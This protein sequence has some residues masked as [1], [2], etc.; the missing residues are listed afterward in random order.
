MRRHV[1]NISVRITFAKNIRFT[2]YGDAGDFP[3]P[4]ELIPLEAGNRY[5]SM[6]LQASELWRKKEPAYYLHTHALVSKIL[7]SLMADREQQYMQ[8]SKYALIASA[9]DHI[10]A[11]FREPIS[12][13]ALAERCGISDEYLRTLFRSYTGQTPLTYINTL[14]LEHARE[15]LLGGYVSVAEA[16]RQSGFESPEYFSRMFKKRYNISPSKLNSVQIQLPSIFNQNGE[17]PKP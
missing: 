7:A 5:K 9:L 11:H 8:S 10:R 1:I 2:L 13:A 6:F 3:F 15:L 12:V 17:E 16:A 4:P 14:R